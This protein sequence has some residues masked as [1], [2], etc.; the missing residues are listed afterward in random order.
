MFATTDKGTAALSRLK[1]VDRIVFP[2][3]PDHCVVCNE[4]IREMTTDDLDIDKQ[5]Y[6]DFAWDRIRDFWSEE[7][8]FYET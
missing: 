6:I 7:G 8:E 2:N 5:W 4:D 3:T 1:K